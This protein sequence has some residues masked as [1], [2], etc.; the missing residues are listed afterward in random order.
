MNVIHHLPLYQ[1]LT[2]NQD[3]LFFFFYSIIIFVG[4]TNIFTFCLINFRDTTKKYLLPPQKGNLKNRKCLVLDL[5]ETLVHS[6]FKP[7]PNADFIVHVEIEKVIHDVS[8]FPS[9]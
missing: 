7:V 9:V 5:D 4:N 8:I 3:C 1:V 2:A 6:S